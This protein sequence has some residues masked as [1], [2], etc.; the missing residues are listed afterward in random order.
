MLRAQAS[1]FTDSS[2]GVAA[3]LGVT[4][5]LLENLPGL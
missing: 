3:W 5:L 2:T 1:D 4:P